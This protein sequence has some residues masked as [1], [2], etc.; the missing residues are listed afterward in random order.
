MIDSLKGRHTLTNGD[1]TSQTFACALLDP[2][3]TTSRSFGK[4]TF[5]LQTT[6]RW[7]PAFTPYD[8]ARS[9]FGGYAAQECLVF[10]PESLQVFSRGQCGVLTRSRKRIISR[11]GMVT[12][13]ELESNLMTFH[14][15]SQL[16][17]SLRQS[18]RAQP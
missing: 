17:F 14:Q 3:F 18:S 16:R 9:I 8:H 5:I 10:I 13:Q 1:V 15:D 2:I 6:I 7:F 4:L 12:F 11:C